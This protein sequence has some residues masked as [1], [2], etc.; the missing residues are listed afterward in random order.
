MSWQDKVV[1]VTG[2]AVGIGA[3]TAKLFAAEGAKVVIVDLEP[4][5]A[6]ETLRAINA[7]DGEALFMRASVDAEKEVAEVRDAIVERFGRIDVLVNNAGIMRRH[8]HDDWTIAEVRQVMDV[9]L[10][11]QFITTH[12]MSP[13]MA[14]GGGGSVVNI[15]SMGAVIPVPYSPVYAAS[16]AG[17]LGFTR[18]VA[19]ALADQN[20][21]VNAVLPSFVDTPMTQNA[22]ARGTMPMMDAREI[23]RAISHVAGDTSLTGA[24]FAVQLTDDGASL[25]KIEDQPRFSSVQSFRS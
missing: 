23:A 9:N 25:D 20:V 24:L 18:S 5:A 8:P 2:G 15:A 16:K 13:V 21:R 19:E 3:A 11:G 10:I 22:P 12:L 14:K 1:I 6:Q 17:V 4:S 7:A